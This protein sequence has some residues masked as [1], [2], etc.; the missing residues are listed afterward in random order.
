VGT[1]PD[2]RR[3][4]GTDLAE[5]AERDGS[6]GRNATRP[7][8]YNWRALKQVLLRTWAGIAEDHLSI[9]AAGIA[10]FG[11]LAAFPSLAALIAIFGLFADPAIVAD[12]LE[13]VR[14]VLPS[15][16]Y[17]IL[18]GQLD[19]LLSAG[20]SSLG[21]ASL[22]AL[23]LALWS[24]RAGASAMI[25]GL[26]I[27]YGE[28]D[29]RNI[30]RQYLSSLVLTLIVL[31]M[32]ILALLVVVALPAVLTFLQ[33][34]EIG[35]L[36]AWIARVAPL[37]VLGV[38][39]VFVV[40]AVYRMGPHR[41]PARKRW[42]TPGAVMATVTWVLASY[43]LSSYISQFGNFN[44]TYGSL[45]AIIALLL[46]LYVTAFV[47]LLGAKLNA[48]LELGTEHDT[49]TGPPRPMGERGAYVADH[50]A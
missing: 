20:T 27:V 45:G 29:T 2:R 11:M 38:A 31:A 16:A 19:R 37:L 6:A 48:E 34:D 28:R 41:A 3:D 42:I 10:F 12:N 8:Q 7:S 46:W 9:I 33:F 17:A 44:Q 25:E 47:V 24:S 40:G 18:E 5:V 30:V 26:N 36:G 14:P 4:E 13:R 21:L 50:V 1:R 32:A 15:D 39:V 35:A 23:A 22:I 49:T 43:L